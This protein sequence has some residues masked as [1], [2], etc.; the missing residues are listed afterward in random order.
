MPALPVQ[1]NEKN[2]DAG[3]IWWDLSLRRKTFVTS[4]EHALAGSSPDINL[5]RHLG[6]GIENRV[7]AR[8]C[9]IE[10]IRYEAAKSDPPPLRGHTSMPG[11]EK[12]RGTLKIGFIPADAKL[13]IA[14]S[15]HHGNAAYQKTNLSAVV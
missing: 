1:L 10:D 12:P 3:K 13:K 15:I 11:K 2:G 9:P 7:N 5:A 8:V 6:P 4:H 14:A